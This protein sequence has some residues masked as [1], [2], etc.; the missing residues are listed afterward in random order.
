VVSTN[1]A[2]TGSY[3]IKM[4]VSDDFPMTM[5]TSF[6]LSV[7]NAAPKV[8]SV[9]GD[10]SLLHKSSLTIPLASN[11]KDDDGDPITME[12]TYKL[13][14]G[15]AETKIPNGIF[16]F[17]SPFTIGVIST[18]IADTGVYT[19]T[20]TVS[21]LL[22]ASVTQ[23]FT[24]TVTNAAPRVVSPP[25]PNLSVVHG[26]S[27][28]IPLAG[29]FIDDDGDTITMTATYSLNGVAG[30]KIPGGLFTLPTPFTIKATSSGL[31]DVGIYT[32]SV[33]VSDSNFSVSDSFTLE[34]T[35]ASPRELLTPIAVTAPQNKL[36][37][38]DLT[39]Y[40]IDD[41]GDPMTLA[42]TY[43]LNGGPTTSIP[44]GIFIKPS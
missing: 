14:G 13:N 42:A 12:A 7:T 38:M 1:I 36:T 26:K 30:Q 9:P 11:F 6:T 43:S 17:L 5:S 24:V 2:D 40:F 37:S 31:I 15:S 35:N 39:A 28:S 8:D 32:I 23:K 21:D 20:L 41:D 29:S 34:V 25:L 19:I 3:L 10:V 16:S 33:E 27:I 44:G 18:S 4:L 22:P